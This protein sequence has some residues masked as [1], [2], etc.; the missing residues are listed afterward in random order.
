[1]TCQRL[2][3]HTVQ[4]CV[5]PSP[6]LTYLQQCNSVHNTHTINIMHFKKACWAQLLASQHRET[7]SSCYLQR[8]LCLFFYW[9]WRI[10]ERPSSPIAAKACSLRSPQEGWHA[11]DAINGGSEPLRCYKSIYGGRNARG[12]EAAAE[13]VLHCSCS[14]VELCAAQGRC[15]N[16][17]KCQLA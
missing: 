12:Q 11:S 10:K 17:K 9:M 13:L 7:S 6:W 1:M 15:L 4:Q 5:A 8:M 3:K 2:H 16:L 14:K